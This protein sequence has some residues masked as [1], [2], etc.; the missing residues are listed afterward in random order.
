MAEKYLPIQFFEKRKDFDDRATE[1]GGDSKLPSW[2][3]TGT[4]LLQHSAQLVSEI[5]NVTSVL[6]EHKQ[7]DKKLP[8]VVCTTIGEKAIAK[9]H[10]SSIS[11]L[12]DDKER[13]N[14]LGFHGNCGLLTMV[15]D[16]N[17]LSEI[18]QILSDTHNQAKLISSITDIAPFYPIVD[19]YD[20]ETHFY[21]IRLVNYNNFDLNLAVNILFEQQCADK[22]IMISHKTKYTS[23]MTIY[24]VCLD[25]AEQLAL[26][27]EFEGVYTIE[28][29][30][31][32]EA[33][34]DALPQE[35]TIIPKKYD[36]ERSYPIVGVLD[37]GIADN[38]FLQNWKEA[39]TFTSYP[40]EY[41]NPAHGTFVSGIVE[42][43]D[44]LNGSSYTALPG[45]R[46]FDAT[47]YPDETK[48][49]IFPDDLIEHIREAIERHNDIKIWNL[50]LG[51]ADETSINEFS[52]FGMA[53]DNIQ[54]EN[55]VLII[56]S[57]GNCT[58][59][60]RQLP[61]S[62]IAK[63][64]DS[65]RAIVVGSLAQKQ[66]AYDYAEANMPSPFTRIGPGPSS[67]V[68]PDLVFY[69]GN[70]GMNNGRLCTTGVPSFT[71]DGKI[72]YNVGTSFST[73]WVS[74]LAAELSYLMN[75]EFDPLLIRA[76]M[77]HNAK[78]PAHCRMTMSNKVAQMGFG[79]PQSVKEMLYNSADE[80]TLILRDTL[81]KG[82]FIEM[83]D[84]PYPTSL[85]DE[86]GYFAG[87]IILT[88]VT[89]SLLDDKQAGEYCQ[90]DIGILFGT[91]ATEKNRDTSKRTVKNPK[92][93]DEPQNLL[94]D[95]CYSSRA[96][97]VYP[98]T[99]FERECTLVKYGKKFHPV[100][101]YAIDLSDMT[102]SNKKKYLD[103]DRKWYL[104][105]NGL[106]RDF[107]ER[108]AYTRNYQL[109]QEYCLLLTIRDPQGKVPVYDEVSQQ[110]DYKNF[111]HHNIQLRNII[112]I[113]GES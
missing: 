72:A 112:T 19:E 2:V 56:K 39:I 96:K 76:L 62:R 75:E 90:S 49:H 7:S 6:H 27:G 45:V 11:D 30:F 29:L 65:I 110:L 85:V 88:L 26:L 57:A 36:S 10:R 31:P 98:K 79:M 54:D 61:K 8:L 23:D 28:K 91:Y 32:V 42:Y 81:D 87:Q 108:D 37:T 101:K 3:L 17:I 43:G 93:L 105:I 71:P 13:S 68:K 21:K 22:G 9:S 38:Q 113:N 66:G 24:R 84:F 109:S 44:E 18:E 95:S 41:Q 94:L 67:I 34:L 12:F 25:S 16:E 50:S 99:G 111:V 102:P 52:D 74:R 63:S 104:Q 78:Y 92:G 106:F 73:P 58:N 82:S 64:A 100:K 53:L 51:T 107:I 89:K 14:V 33:T 40:N 4:D 69:G 60:M 35:P 70:A 46:L 80:I 5:N 103:K 77:I 97:G 86:N 20:N 47:V 48:E 55:N 15:T 59:F 83:F 1:G